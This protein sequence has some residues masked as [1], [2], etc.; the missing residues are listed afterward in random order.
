MRYQAKT[1]YSHFSF[2]FSLILK[3]LAHSKRTF[4][5]TAISISRKKNIR[6]KKHFVTKPRWIRAPGMLDH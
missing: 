3:W 6:Q 4:K 1:F 5:I 2:S